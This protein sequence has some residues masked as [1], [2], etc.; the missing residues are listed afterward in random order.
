MAAAQ[1]VEMGPKTRL[2]EALENVV[3][4]PDS[5]GRL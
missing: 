4:T 5:K 2:E 1:S 3:K